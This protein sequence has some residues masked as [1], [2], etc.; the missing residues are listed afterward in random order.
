[1]TSLSLPG[2]AIQPWGRHLVS[3]VLV[4]ALLTTS[5]RLVGHEYG[6]YAGYVILQYVVLA[7]AWNIL[8]GYAGYVNFGA[9]AFFAAGA[10]STVVLH[11][12]FG[13]GLLPCIVGGGIVSGLM[14]LA[15]GY[16]TLRL[17]GVYFSIATLSLAVL[18]QTLVVNW[19][20][21]G[22]ASGTYLIRPRQVAPFVS[23]GE[24]LFVIML[25]MALASIAIASTIERSRLGLGLATI[26]DDERAAE[27]AGVPTLKLKLVATVISGALMGMAGAPLPYYSSYL[28][29]ESAFALSYTVNAMA[30]PLIGGTQSWIG[31][32][33]GA[34]L[35]GSLQQIA[36][37]TISSSANMLIV[38]GVLVGFVAL[39]PRGI[40]GWVAGRR[41]AR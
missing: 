41:A 2:P 18:L 39:A 35:L 4:L 28:N 14:G 15:T 11:K 5:L 26:R 6:Y 32:V 29:P 7:T 12:A 25:V 40:L 38:G 8:G 31:P 23:Y 33:I 24:Y 30:M 37:V 19:S 10:Y 17:R 3:S 20:Y 27:A 34:F 16:L 9:A 36:T 1:M 22:G 21:V 13:L